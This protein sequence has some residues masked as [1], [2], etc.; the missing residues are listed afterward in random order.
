MDAL[1]QV[2]RAFDGGYGPADPVGELETL[3]LE[4]ALADL[5]IVESRLE[6]L[7][8]DKQRLG[9]LASPPSRS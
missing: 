7:A 3:V 8:K 6:R 4:L 5:Q 1:A 9:K 2:V